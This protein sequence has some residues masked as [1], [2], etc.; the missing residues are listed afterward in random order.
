MRKTSTIEAAFFVCL[1]LLSA[2]GVKESE[3]ADMVI[4]NAAV[5]TCADK[6]PWAEAVAVRDGRIVFVGK[7]K[8]AERYIGP[9]TEVMDLAGKMLLPGFIDSHMHPTGNVITEL[10]SISL[11]QNDSVEDMLA[12]IKEFVDAN[13]GLDAYFGGGWS[14]GQ[15]R[16]N[17]TTL[18]PKKERL[19]AICSTAP[20][21]LRSYDGHSTWVNSRALEMG[22]ITK[23]TPDPEGGII[24]RN[25]STG[26]PWGTLR[27]SAARLV[28]AVEYS[29]EQQYQAAIAFQ[30]FMHS[31]GYTGVFSAGSSE[32]VFQAFK[33]LDEEGKLSLWIRGS[34]FIGPGRSG[35]VDQDLRTQI[36][37][38]IQD[39]ERMR[40]TYNSELVKI[41]TAKFFIDGVVEG[42]TA[43]VIEP[44]TEEAGKGEDYHGLNYWRDLNALDLLNETF[45]D[46]LKRGIQI[47]VHSIGD[48]ATKDIVDALEYAQG[49][50]PGN[51]RNVI[52]HLQLV[53]PED[54]PRFKELG[55]IANCQVYW[56]FKEPNWWEYVDGPF[57]GE[58]GEHEYPLG[59]F[60]KAGVMIAGSSDYPVTEVPMPLWAIE[61]GVTR[62][63]NSADY[64]EGDDISSMDDPTY[65]LDKNE[66]VS[67]ED[68]IKCYTCNN[69]YQLFIEGL[70]GTIEVGKYADLVVLGE[71]L[72]EVDP[73]HIDSVPIEM[74]IFHGEVVFEGE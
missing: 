18:G 7:N 34:Q 68:M 63:L 73:L 22:G 72:F 41:I 65:L 35:S 40:T 54:I 2:C 49:K 32:E 67:L 10:Y 27:E 71:N 23:F 24:E 26:E 55:I 15:F 37:D 57:L 53:C 70:T 28:P 62:N 51:Y 16:G 64:Y 5:F 46:L 21:I 11:G 39:L 6:T 4:K 9:D 69:A 33:A 8:G 38:Q 52:T 17:E 1:L 13:P 66:R 36:N 50:V 29:Y 25:P 19:D 14:V 42:V 48:R 31:L 56:D 30:E 74:T 43:S 3:K 44:Y 45:A 59:S 61:A 12:A 20:I 60:V 47:H 58:R